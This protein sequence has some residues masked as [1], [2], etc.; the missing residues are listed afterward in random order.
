MNVYPIR[1][2]RT[3]QFKYIRNLFPQYE[4]TTHIDRAKNADGL[5]YWSTWVAAGKTD[6]VA[7]AIVKRYHERPAEEL[8]D[9]VKDPGEK[10]N[11]AEKPEYTATLQVLRGKVDAW[12]K[13]QGDRGELFNQPYPLG[14]PEL[15]GKPEGISKRAN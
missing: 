13:E 12:M 5:K 2:V 6:A 10:D 4:H 7:A 3:E 9:I 15:T 11:L 8:Y 1:S 14:T